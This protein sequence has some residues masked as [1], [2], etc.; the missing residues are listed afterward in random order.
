LGNCKFCG[1]PAGFLHTQHAECQEQH[2]RG[3][4]EI[5]GLISTFLSSTDPLESLLPRVNEIA[6]RSYVAEGDEHSL[7]LQGW[8]TGVEHGLEDG[9]LTESEE[10][11]LSQYKDRFS[12]TQDELNHSGAF[13]K[14]VKAAVIRDALNGIIK[15][16]ITLEGDSPINFQKGE[17]IAW[18]FPKADYLE[19]TNRREYVGSSSGISIRVVKGLYYRTGAFKGHPVDRT[20]RVHVDTGVVVVTDKNI[21]FAG[22]SKSLRVPYNKIVS[23]QPFSDGI[24]IIR[25]AANAKPQIF[26]TGDGWFTF[27]LV[28]NLAKL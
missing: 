12:L 23:F 5:T 10:A 20:E 11:R 28:T 2:D 9:I 22:P 14:L 3:T 25:D 4:H 1:K 18:A 6:Q 26:V 19:D 24:G 8:V 13:T 27:N 21:Y 16:R 7:L 15:P 17:Q